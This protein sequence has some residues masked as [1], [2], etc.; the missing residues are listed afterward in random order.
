MDRE[1]A[2]RL[3][4][5]N[6]EFYQDNAA[7]FSSSRQ[8]P[9]PGWQICLARA[10]KG[11]PHL[12][13]ALR[14]LDLACG[15]LRFATF[16]RSELP[17]TILSY[18]AVDNCDAL[19]PHDLPVNYQHL[20][21]LDVLLQG[22]R[23]S[24]AIE[25]PE[26]DLSVCFGFMHHVPCRE[27]RKAVLDSLIQHTRPGGYIMVTFWQFLKD[28]TLKAKALALQD[29]ALKEKDLPILDEG[30]FLLDWDNLPGVYRYC[31][32]FSNSEIFKLIKGV[33]PEVSLVSHFIADGRANTLNFYIVLKRE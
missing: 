27:Y 32:N 20:D 14:V 29:K 2:R 13:E 19:V 26:C 8:T 1:T 23:L 21:L 28:N 16:L 12:H 17:Q 33:L 10:E 22:H 7:S 18:Y 15:N 11:I 31:H 25:A 24:E 6:T 3:C 30:D 4:E 9:W 5:L